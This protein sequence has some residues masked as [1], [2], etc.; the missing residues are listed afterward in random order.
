MPIFSVGLLL[1]ITVALMKVSLVGIPDRMP[2]TLAN[3][4]PGGA[5]G[6]VFCA[7]G[8]GSGTGANKVE[9]GSAVIA[10]QRGGLLPKTT[11]ALNGLIVRTYMM[12]EQRTE[13]LP[14]EEYVRGVIAAEM[15]AD[16]ELE[17]LKAQAI[18][19][20]TYIVRRLASGDDSG[21]ENVEADV[22]DT[23]AHQ[24]YLPLAQLKQHWQGAKQT[25]NMKKLNE[26]VKQ[27]EGLIVT[28]NRRADPGCFFLHKQWIYGKF[29]R[30]LVGC[31]FLIRAGVRRVHG[32][33]SCHRDTKKAWS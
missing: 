5:V 3:A 17:A 32:T 12:K 16:F 26:A 9:A 4:Q 1:G 28:Y 27:T 7:P 15:P 29:R 6:T 18:A 30:L 21:V 20:R 25:A 13:S 2:A 14:L 22:T 10:Q 31:R 8:T 11:G 19:A 33:S 24:A 23:I